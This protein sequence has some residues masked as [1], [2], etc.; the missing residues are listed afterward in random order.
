[1]QVASVTC[2][3][4]I[5]PTMLRISSLNASRFGR[6]TSASGQKCGPTRIF[7]FAV[8]HLLIRGQS[9]LV[10]P[11]IVGFFSVVAVHLECDVDLLQGPISLVIE[12]SVDVVG[13]ISN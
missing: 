11:D 13:L 8:A 6:P 5:F 12:I 2:W 10:E 7:I 3:P 9:H 1:M 4:L